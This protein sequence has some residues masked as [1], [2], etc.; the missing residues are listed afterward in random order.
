M[1]I[2]FWVSLCLVVSLIWSDLSHADGPALAVEYCLDTFNS[3]KVKTQ[4]SPKCGEIYSACMKSTGGVIVRDDGSISQMYH[5]DNPQFKKCLARGLDIE[6]SAFRA[7]MNEANTPAAGAPKSPA[8]SPTPQPDSGSNEQAGAPAESLENSAE[9]RA[10]REELQQKTDKCEEES[11]SAI[12]RCDEKNDSGMSSAAQSAAQLA[13]L[14]GQKAVADI[15]ASCMNMATLSQGANS[16]VEAFKGACTSSQSTCTSSCGEVTSFIEQRSGVCFPHLNGAERENALVPFR[17]AATSGIQSCE[18]LQ[19]KIAD[20]DKLLQSL[21]L[22]VASAAQCYDKT[23]GG[24][25][26]ELKAICVANPNYAGCQAATTVDCSK[27]EHATSNKICICAKNPTDPSCLNL[28]KAG[29]G[30]LLGAVDSSSR[31]PSAASSFGGDLP[32]LPGISQGKLNAGSSSDAV[33]GKQGGGAQLGGLGG[34]SGGSGAEGASGQAGSEDV[35]VL[36]GFYGSGGSSSGY[37]RAFGSVSQGSGVGASA[38]ARTSTG[39]DLK[40]FLPGGQYDPRRSAAGVSGPD[41]ITGPHSNIWQKI[42]NRYQ[43]LGAS[44]MP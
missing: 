17:E 27:P 21:A 38:G 39:P 35:K 10:C 19:G 4:G 6:S 16:A 13:V 29:S 11:R 32:S 26:A 42:Q 12:Y 5:P 1:A 7:C 14:A 25:S 2:G 3:C 9:A 24:T 44:F 22:T 41:G 18:R 43:S 20:S 40:K 37:A 30:A 28:A 31:L 36:G 8:P 33:D 34:G 23:Y 15:N